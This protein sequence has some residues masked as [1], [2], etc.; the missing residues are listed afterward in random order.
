MMSVS[1]LLVIIVLSLIGSSNCYIPVSRTELNR[2]VTKV[3][4]IMDAL[5]KALANDPNLPPPKNP[6]LSNGPGK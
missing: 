4:G 2:D 1:K 6:G 5:N 3:Y